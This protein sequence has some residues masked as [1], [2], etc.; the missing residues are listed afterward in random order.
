MS[1][2][3]RPL[4]L[5]LLAALVLHACSLLGVSYSMAG[6]GSALQKRGDPLLTRSITP[7]DGP[8]P[9][10]ALGPA[11]LP[12]PAKAAQSAASPLGQTMPQPVAAEPL[13]TTASVTVTAAPVSPSVSPIVAGTTTATALA[14]SNTVVA[15]ASATTNFSES[16]PGPTTASTAAAAGTG[17]STTTSASGWTWPPDTRLNYKLGGNFRGEIFGTA[18]VQWSKYKAAQT[19]GE[20]YQVR[21]ALN[22]S[23]LTQSLTSQGRVLPDKLEPLVY[24]EQ[25]T[26]G[27]PRSV[28]IAPRELRLEDGQTLAV[29]PQALGKLQ[30]TASQFVDLTYRFSTGLAQLEAGKTV[31]VWLARPGG[32]DEWIYD[33]NPPETLYLPKLGAVQAYHLKPRPLANPR[34][35]I[36]AEMWYAPSL[37]YMPVRIKILQGKELTIDLLV[38]SIEQAKR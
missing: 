6:M 9:A 23:G 25:R 7:Q 5:A 18:Q 21:I 13:A 1:A 15:Q 10:K 34:G 27:K 4:T 36:T 37:Q 11:P 16:S 2:W 3:L 35:N 30:D 19:A 28:R 38:E 26:G 31:N 17:N 12:K 22:I 32:L 20:E 24:E 29:P 14:P 8:A 33:I